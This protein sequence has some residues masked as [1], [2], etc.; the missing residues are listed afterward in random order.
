MIGFK[1]ICKNIVIFSEKNAPRILASLASAGVIGTAVATVNATKASDKLIEDHP[2]VKDDI[3]EEAKLTWKVWLP[4]GI[5][6]G[7]SIACIA[8]ATHISA[9]RQAALASAYLISENALSEYKDQ[10]LEQLGPNKSKKLENNIIQEQV[11]AHPVPEE[12]LIK[13]T[14]HGNTLFYDALTGRYFRASVESL[15]RIENEI[16]AHLLDENWI[17]LNDI[18]YEIGLDTISPCVGD[19]FGVDLH[20]NGFLD[21]GYDAMLAPNDEPCVVITINA[22]PKHLYY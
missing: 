10:V 21:M 17:S 12:E 22:R 1:E 20:F 18:Y 9:A 14:G 3:L 19:E 11:S 7:A 4:V 13:Y 2:E 15:K 8:G 5:M 6:A 16:N